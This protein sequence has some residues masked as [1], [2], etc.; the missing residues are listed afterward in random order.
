M[1]S[2]VKTLNGEARI[3]IGGPYG[4]FDD[5]S[6]VGLFEAMAEAAPNASFEG[7][8]YGFMTGAEISLKANLSQEILY[9]ENFNRPDEY[10]PDYVDTMVEKI[11]YSAFCEIAKINDDEFDEYNYY[12]FFCKIEGCDL[13]KMKFDKFMSYC[14]SSK[15]EEDDYPKFIKKMLGLGYMNKDQFDKHFDNSD[16]FIE[17]YTYN[18]I[19]KCVI[20]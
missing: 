17:K 16:E 15:L 5:L 8:S 7:W 18:P 3:E 1:P 12:D 4:V 10:C 11:S 9:I 14:E 2:F 20:R 13:R 19:K 6:N